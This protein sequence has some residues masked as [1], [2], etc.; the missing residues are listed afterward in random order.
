[1]PAVLHPPSASMMSAGQR[2]ARKRSQKLCRNECTRQ[3]SGRGPWSCGLTVERIGSSC[4]GQRCRAA[5]WMIHGIPPQTKPPP[6]ESTTPIL[7]A[8]CP[9]R[10]VPRSGVPGP[11]S[12]SST[13][14]IRH[15]NPC[16]W[17][18]FHDPWP[19]VP[20]GVPKQGTCVAFVDF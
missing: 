11:H 10:R 20:L 5:E 7:K 1:M 2:A 3:P 12:C 9:R 19:V 8:R 17:I 15:S 16:R 14:A 4:T 13:V 6:N 18:L